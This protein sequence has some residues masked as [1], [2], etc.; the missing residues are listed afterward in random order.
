MN[1]ISWEYAFIHIPKNAG[2]SIKKAIEHCQSIK[3]FNHDV[4]FKDIEQLKEIIII[5][6]PIDRFTS[7]FFYLK[8]YKTNKASVYFN[9][10]EDLLKGFLNYDPMALNYLKI[11]DHSH[12]VNG[13]KINTDWVFHPQI[14]WVNNPYKIFLYENIE[15]DFNNFLTEIGYDIKIPHVNRSNKIDFVY[16]SDSIKLL[17]LLYKLDFELYESL[18]NNRDGIG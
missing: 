1:D 2:F 15:N 10:P 14:S 16:N 6:N 5:R 13:N 12:H 18:L 4:L 11:H 3:Y 17:K 9:T 7:A 8:Q